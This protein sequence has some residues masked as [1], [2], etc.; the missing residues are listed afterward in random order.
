MHILQPK[1]TKLSEKEAQELLDSLNISP[2]QLPKIL[3]DDVALPEG[4]QIG[5]II[6]IERKE[7]SKLYIYY[8]VVV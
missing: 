7:D 4:C 3:L 5:N 1:H 6:K 8:R 2:S